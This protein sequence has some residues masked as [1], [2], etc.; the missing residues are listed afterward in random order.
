MALPSRQ[1]ALEKLDVS[2]TQIRQF[3]NSPI[4]AE[5]ASRIQL[6]P[7]YHGL[8]ESDVVVINT[9]VGYDGDALDECVERLEQLLGRLRHETRRHSVLYWG[10]IQ[11]TSDP[12]HNKLLERFQQLFAA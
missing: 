11:R 1:G 9:G 12:T 5:I 6:Q 4:G 3:I 8:V 10:N 2:E 7:A